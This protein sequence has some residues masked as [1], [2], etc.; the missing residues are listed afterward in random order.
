[1]SNYIGVPGGA[2]GIQRD[3]RIGNLDSRQQRVNALP[4]RDNWILS[5][6]PVGMVVDDQTVLTANLLRLYFIGQIVRET[7]I[8]QARVNITTAAASQRVRTALYRYDIENVTNRR[9]MKLPESEATFLGDSAGLQSINLPSGAVVT[10]GFLFLGVKVSNDAVG[11]GGLDLA[12]VNRTMPIYTFQDNSG[13]MAPVLD[14]PLLTK[15][16]T[17]KVLDVLYLSP[18]AAQVL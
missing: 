15:S 8:R 3:E 5:T 4:A 2:P 9:F 11:V 12:V 6:L 10:P 14:I 13:I 18:D 1:M 17:G 16:Y 7:A